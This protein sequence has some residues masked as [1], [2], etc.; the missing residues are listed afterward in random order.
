MFSTWYKI[1]GLLATT[2]VRAFIVIASCVLI[3]LAL[4]HVT[5]PYQSLCWPLN[6]HWFLCMVLSMSTSRRRPPAMIYYSCN[7]MTRAGSI[8]VY[9]W[10]LYVPNYAWEDM[11]FQMPNIFQS[12]WFNPSLRN[13]CESKWS[14]IMRKC[15]RGHDKSWITI[16]Y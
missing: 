14:K 3:S 16:E 12:T 13:Q 15:V 8:Q 9:Q 1:L 6:Y 11:G 7:S 5:I 2:C 4:L 10:Y